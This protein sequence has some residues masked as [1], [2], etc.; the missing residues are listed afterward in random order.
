[1]TQCETLEAVLIDDGTLDTV[2]T[3]RN[4]TWKMRYAQDS[5]VADAL[6]SGDEEVA[7]EEC[8][9]DHWEDQV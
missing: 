2:V 1:M 4:C 9:E 5:A 6:A 3:C 8:C 7:F